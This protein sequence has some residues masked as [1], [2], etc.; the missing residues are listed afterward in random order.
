MCWVFA[1]N[2]FHSK[3]ALKAIGGTFMPSMGNATRQD[4]YG[5]IESV[6]KAIPSGVY[7]NGTVGGVTANSDVTNYGYSNNTVSVA[8][9]VRS[10]HS[11]QHVYGKRHQWCSLL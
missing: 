2:T 3:G 10:W 6:S 4:R 5:W 9:M 8:P 7:G 1:I 11:N